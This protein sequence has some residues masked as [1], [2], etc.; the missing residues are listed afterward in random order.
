MGWRAERARLFCK[1][2]CDIC[3]TILWRET[4]RLEING[5]IRSLTW[6]SN[7]V[8]WRLAPGKCVSINFWAPALSSASLGHS[9]PPTE[10]Y[11]TIIAITSVRIKYSISL[12]HLTKK[13]LPCRMLR[14][15]NRRVRVGYIRIRIKPGSRSMS[16]WRKQ[17]QQL[18]C[19]V[20][21]VSQMKWPFTS[22]RIWKHFWDFVKINRRR[23]GAG[24]NIP[25]GKVHIGRLR[26]SRASRDFTQRLS[27]S[28]FHMVQLHFNK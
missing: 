27:I 12:H 9:F 20:L 26:R 17:A 25:W 19:P 16:L 21:P 5:S 14:R 8:D 11:Y 13:C 22:V 18:V 2:F 15:R 23:V 6:K 4:I 10:V 24:I 1:R 7:L 3:D 28:L